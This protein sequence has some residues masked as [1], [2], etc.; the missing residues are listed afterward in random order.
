[1]KIEAALIK[2]EG[3]PFVVYEYDTLDDVQKMCEYIKEKA[4][5][6][7]LFRYYPE[8]DPDSYN[9]DFELVS[10]DENKIKTHEDRINNPDKKTLLLSEDLISYDGTHN[11]EKQEFLDIDSVNGYP[12][13]TDKLDI[14]MAINVLEDEVWKRLLKKGTIER[15]R[16]YLLYIDGKEAG[17]CSNGYAAVN[18]ED[19]LKIAKILEDEFKG[20]KFEFVPSED[21]EIFPKQ[22]INKLFTKALID[23]KAHFQLKGPGGNGENK[24][25]GQPGEN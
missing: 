6:I 20:H 5:D 19:L 3:I 25:P 4:F 23:T 8:Q 24:G 1:M 11:I 16:T 15:G 22:H 2:I 17:L 10:Y 18:K 21:K 14:V 9:V 7:D 13:I 12:I